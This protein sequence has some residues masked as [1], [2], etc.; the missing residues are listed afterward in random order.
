MTGV[1]TCALPICG[2]I[3]PGIKLT[4]EALVSGTAKLPHFELL[5]PEKVIGRTTVANLQ[6]G[7]INGYVGQVI[8]LVNEMRREMGCP[9]AKVIA[10]GGMARLIAAKVRRVVASVRLMKRR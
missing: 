2:C 1:Q 10:T 5:M 4:S 8:Y 7:V 9:G 3:C 6:S